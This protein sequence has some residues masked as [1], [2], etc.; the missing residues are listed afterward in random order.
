MATNPES[1]PP[2]SPSSSS[3]HSASITHVDCDHIVSILHLLPPDSILS[4]SM[5]CKR[6]RSLGSSNNLWEAICR[7][8]WG[9]GTVDALV[10]TLAPH[11]KTGLYWKRLYRRVSQLGS[12]SCRRISSKGGCFPTPR[13]SHSL[14][15][16]DDWIVLFGGGCE[17]GRHLDDTWVAY[18][19][20]GFSRVLSWQQVNSGMPS[21]RFGQSCILVGDSLV[22]FGGI[23]DSG[24]RLNDTWIGQIIR[25][26]PFEIKVL[27]RLLEVGQ[28][29]PPPRGAHAACCV[30]DRIMVIHGGIGL[31]GLRLS[32]T[33]L[34]DL[35][36]GLKS[37]R[38]HKIENSRPS[39]PPRSG[40]TLTWIGQTHVVLFGGRGSGYEVL[41]DVWFFDVGGIYPEWKELKCELSSVL[42]EM[43]FPR[44]GHSATPI[45]GGKVLIYGGEDS[46]RHRKDDFW[47]LDVPSLLSFQ[48]GSRK[49]LQ[50]MW[51]KLVI[52]GQCPNYRSFHGACTDR[53]GRYIYVF[54]GMVDGLIYPAE[55][56]DLRF[57]G[58]LYQMELM[59]QS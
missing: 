49:S 44:V 46:H 26:G 2:S 58:E 48:S 33:W 16:V 13:A 15:F 52:E 43:P 39:P 54:G 19:G 9:S 53:S 40:H 42:G 47:V 30:G 4:F 21:G 41:N 34:L 36:D 17:G 57:D 51:K 12:L 56:Y 29:A 28:S 3:R 55:A 25:E 45:L 59:L 22:L 11:E 8:D 27:W 24:V 10:G 6:F 5:T 14:N 37:G 23:N 35:S 38:W 20:N 18:I 1:P 32:D 50:K 7:R 31:Y